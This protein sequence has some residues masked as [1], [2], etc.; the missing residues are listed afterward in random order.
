MFHIT[1]V[2][3]RATTTWLIF[4][5]IF[6]VAREGDALAATHCAG[7]VSYIVFVLWKM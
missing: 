2:A 7:H 4:I 5:A 6:S 3:N 1:C